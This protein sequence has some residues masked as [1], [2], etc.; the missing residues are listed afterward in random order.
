MQLGHLP[1]VPLAFLPTPL[2]DAPRLTAALGGP[3]IMIKRD[4]QTGLALGGNKA[5]KLE[6][7]MGEALRQGATVVITTGGA[8]SNHTRMT[9]AAAR[10]LGLQSVLVLGGPAP[11]QVQGN[12]LLDHLLGADIRFVEAEDD[13][14][15]ERAMDDAADELRRK[16]QR[17]YVIPVGG[18]GPT[19]ALGY[20][21][22]FLEC[23][24]QVNQRGVRVGRI[25]VAGGSGG[26]LTGLTLGA[27][28]THSGVQV[29]GIS[30]SRAASELKERVA[31]F[32]TG[33]A[34][35]KLNM[36]VAVTE[37]EVTVYDQYVGPGYGKPTP[38]GLEA[39]RTAA[40]TEGLITDPVYTGKCLAGLADLI[41]R[42]EIK[43]GENVVFWHTG[44]APGLFAHAELFKPEVKR[45]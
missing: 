12:L 6:F 35:E 21:A 28:L 24:E 20:V 11:E 1:R 32:A 18:S 41:H 45:T 23:L 25:F 27:K 33:C 42:G 26:T 16:G 10:R 9:A 19:G 40:K 4:D 8:Q 36:D 3:R 43:A 7:L 15:T 14:T 37:D 31:R 22:A 2:E 38:E 30:V 17:P 39:M 5:R 34:R 44:G 13:L 29:V